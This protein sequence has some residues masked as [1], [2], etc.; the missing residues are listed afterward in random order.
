V[1]EEIQNVPE[2]EGQSHESYEDG[3]WG[4]LNHTLGKK[5]KNNE[6]KVCGSLSGICFSF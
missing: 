5:K 2:E 3:T 4:S 6:E 1:E